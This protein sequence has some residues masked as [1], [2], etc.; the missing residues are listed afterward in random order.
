MMMCFYFVLDTLGFTSIYPQSCNIHVHNRARRSPTH[1]FDPQEAM[2]S[3]K[4]RRAFPCTTIENPVYWHAIRVASVHHNSDSRSLL[5][6]TAC[7]VHP[8]IQSFFAGKLLSIQELAHILQNL[9]IHAASTLRETDDVL[10]PHYV[11]HRR[12]RPPT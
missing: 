12:R 7:I 5:V 3:T 2:A 8:I 9:G 4:Y 11:A 6:V 10:R 1:I